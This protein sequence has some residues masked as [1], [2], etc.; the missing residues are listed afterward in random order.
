[1]PYERMTVCGCAFFTVFSFLLFSVAFRRYCVCVFAE[2]H[3][4]PVYLLLLF[5]FQIHR[6]F[7]SSSFSSFFVLFSILTMEQFSNQFVKI[8]IAHKWFKHTMGDSVHSDFVFFLSSFPSVGDEHTHTFQY[9]RALLSIFSRHNVRGKRE[10]VCVC[11]RNPTNLCGTNEY[12]CFIH[13]FG[14][15][16]SF[17]FLFALSAFCCVSRSQSFALILFRCIYASS[18]Q[19]NHFSGKAVKQFGSVSKDIPFFGLVIITTH[20]N[21]DATHRERIERAILWPALNFCQRKSH[22]I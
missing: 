17:H 9:E 7:V 11:M 5:H 16:F 4:L 12:K 3:F 6:L 18:L 22:F 2:W 8:K 14:S 13:L 15:S 20:H 19:T 1:M 21:C 10:R